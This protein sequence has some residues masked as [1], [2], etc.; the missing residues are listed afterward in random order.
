MRKNT[1]YAKYTV[2]PVNNRP[3]DVC[4]PPASINWAFMR[5]VHLYNYK[6]ELDFDEKEVLDKFTSSICRALKEKGKVMIIEG[7]NPNIPAKVSKEI[8]AERVEK[9]SEGRL[10]TVTLKKVSH[11]YMGVFEKISD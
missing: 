7:V 4:L 6:E 1:G 5:D 11:G 8:M 10:K 3:D 2:Y 9:H